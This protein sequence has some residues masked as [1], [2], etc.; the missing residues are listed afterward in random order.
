MYITLIN[1]ILGACDWCFRVC[2]AQFSLPVTDNDRDQV[3]NFCS[4][5]C[6]DHYRLGLC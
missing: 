4:E 1:Y 2:P 3:K 5:A 6:F